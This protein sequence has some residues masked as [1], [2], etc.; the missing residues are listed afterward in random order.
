MRKKDKTI[1]YALVVM[2]ALMIRR[3]LEEAWAY[4]DITVKEA[5]KCLTL[6]VTQTIQIKNKPL[7]QMIPKPN[8]IN[9]NLLNALHM[10]LPKM[11]PSKG[12]KVA[13]RKKLFDRRKK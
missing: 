2:F 1:G 5:I 4:M 8:Q 12:V 11:L 13:T 6:I 9:E 7:L 3:Y 10:K